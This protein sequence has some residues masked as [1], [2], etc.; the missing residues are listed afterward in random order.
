MACIPQNS[1][2][3]QTVA[4]HL[5]S[6][7][8]NIIHQLSDL[9]IHQARLCW[10]HLL[11]V[12][13]CDKDNEEQLKLASYIITVTLPN[14]LLPTLHWPHLY[15]IQQDY[16]KRGL[17]IL[18]NASIVINSSSAVSLS[19]VCRSRAKKTHVICPWVLSKN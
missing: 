2:I 14:F 17:S 5:G 3:L 8:N 12:L 15:L 4:A 18:E 1:E 19:T 6:S 7:G 9:P 10:P 13:L 16:L 11:L